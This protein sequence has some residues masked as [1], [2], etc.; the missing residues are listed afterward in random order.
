MNTGN[1]YRRACNVLCF[2]EPHLNFSTGFWYPIFAVYYASKNHITVKVLVPDSG[3]R[4][5]Q[6]VPA[7]TNRSITLIEISTNCKGNVYFQFG[8]TA[9]KGCCNVNFSLNSCNVCCTIELAC[10]GL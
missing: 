3:I 10:A 7:N 8:L 2:K 4:F 5:L 1:A 9:L 6:L